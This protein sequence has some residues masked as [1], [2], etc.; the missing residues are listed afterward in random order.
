MSHTETT[1]VA[2]QARREAAK[3]ALGEAGLAAAAGDKAAA[4]RTIDL[5]NDLSKIEDEIRTLDAIRRDARSRRV[6]RPEDC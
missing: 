1:L 5:R 2:A 6:H 4:K 3:I